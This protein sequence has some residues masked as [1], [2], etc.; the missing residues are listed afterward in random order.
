MMQ[1]KKDRPRWT[2]F[3]A[4]AKEWALGLCALI[5]ISLMV[6]NP[7]RELPWILVAWVVITAGLALHRILIR[8]KSTLLQ[9]W[10]DQEKARKKMF[11]K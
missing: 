10:K 11:E 9:A 3:L 7:G 4:T 6:E 5:V 1:D 2:F 8:E